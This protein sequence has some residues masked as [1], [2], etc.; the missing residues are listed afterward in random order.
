LRQTAPGT[1]IFLYRRDLD[2]LKDK[3]EDRSAIIHNYSDQKTPETMELYQARLRA[4]AGVQPKTAALIWQSDQTGDEAQRR[5]LEREAVE[6]YF[7]EM[8][9]YWP[10]DLVKGWQRHNPVGVKWLEEFVKLLTAPERILD[11]VNHE[12]VLNWLR[13]GYNLMTENELAKAIY[14]AT[15]LDVK[16]NTVKKKRAALGLQARSPGPRPNSEQ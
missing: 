6:A 10:N 11:P 4:L 15:G 16:P 12:I 8:G 1:K 13:R 7:A 2:D 14:S 3:P 9:T 5:K